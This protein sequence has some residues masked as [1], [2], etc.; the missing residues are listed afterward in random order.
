MQYITKY[1][2]DVHYAIKEIGRKENRPTEAAMRKM[3][4]CVG[5][6]SGTTDVGIWFPVGDG[7]IDDMVIMCDSNWATDAA[8]RKSTSCGTIH[9]NGC[10]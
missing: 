2:P 8:D 1:R 3:K 5:L 7:K 4:R 6:L 10:L 9:V